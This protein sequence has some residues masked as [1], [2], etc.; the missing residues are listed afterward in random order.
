MAPILSL[1]AFII[2]LNNGIFSIKIMIMTNYGFFNS[3]LFQI[4][5]YCGE[6]NSRVHIVN[7]CPN[8]FFTD[9]RV[10]YG[11]LVEE[12]FTDKL[13]LNEALN[14]IYFGP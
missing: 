10:E 8:K 1:N 5:K 11:K 12:Y 3:R 9:I 4:C 13:S 14:E 7:E 2:L 6:N